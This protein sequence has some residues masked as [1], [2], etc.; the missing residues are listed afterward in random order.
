[1]SAGRSL[2]ISATDTG[3]AFFWS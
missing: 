2:F 3:D 1:V